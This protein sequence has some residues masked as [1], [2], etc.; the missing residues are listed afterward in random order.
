[1]AINTPVVTYLAPVPFGLS[2]HTFHYLSTIN[3]VA[4]DRH[5]L[6]TPVVAGLVD[7]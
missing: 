2:G 4:Y 7:C 3:I 6:Y 1:M 5:T